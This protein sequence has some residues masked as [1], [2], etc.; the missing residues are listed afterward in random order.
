MTSGGKLLG[1]RGGGGSGGHGEFLLEFCIAFDGTY[2]VRSS[3]CIQG[4]IRR[5]P[6]TRYETD[7][8]PDCIRAVPP[9]LAMMSHEHSRPA[10]ASIV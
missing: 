1:F 6:R 8:T 4:R 5:F 3:C 7:E 10:A 9:F 2:D